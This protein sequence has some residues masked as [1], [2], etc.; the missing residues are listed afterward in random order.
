MY[1]ITWMVRPVKHL[2]IRVSLVACIS[3]QPFVIEL[4]L[5]FAG[6][7]S[8]RMVTFCSLFVFSGPPFTLPKEIYFYFLSILSANLRALKRLI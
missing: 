5:T 1:A 6:H 8:S 2:E 4:A 7:I 3:F